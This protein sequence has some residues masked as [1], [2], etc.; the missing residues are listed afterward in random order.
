MPS[1]GGPVRVTG[2][3]HTR[4]L[5]GE[6]VVPQLVPDA[7]VVHAWLPL[8]ADRTQ[9]GY[10]TYTTYWA[11]RRRRA[12]I[13][14]RTGPLFALALYGCCVVADEV[15]LSAGW[16][17]IELTPFQAAAAAVILPMLRLLDLRGMMRAVFQRYRPDPTTPYDSN[18]DLGGTVEQRRRRARAA[19]GATR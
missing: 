5:A 13:L 16:R 7:S 8:L 1:P 12:R 19:S 3:L 14:L 11:D 4:L 15:R 10:E 9:K 18:L 17:D 6:G 2:G